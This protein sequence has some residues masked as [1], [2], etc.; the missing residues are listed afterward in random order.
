MTADA[1]RFRFGEPESRAADALIRLALAEDFGETGDLTS[2]ATIPSSARARARFVAR[3]PG[4][5]AGLPVVRRLVE[6]FELLDRWRP[7]TS[8]GD[9]LE[10]ATVIA[11]VSGPA[12]SILAVER[13]GRS[14]SSSRLCG[15]ATLTAR[16]VAAVQG[17]RARIFDTRKTTP[18][19]RPLEKYAVRCGGG[20]NHRIGLHD[21][22]LI[23]DNHL[24]ILRSEGVPDP[25]AAAVAAAR[26][27]APSGT[28][29]E[30]EVDT[31]EDLER[32]AG[33]PPRHRAPG[34]HGRRRVARAPWPGGDALAPGV[35]LEASGG[36]D[37]NT[38]GPLARAG[39]ERISV[40]A[41]HPLGP[42]P[43]HRP[44]FR[45][46]DGL[47]GP[48]DPRPGRVV[49]RF[50]DGPGRCPRG[51]PIVSSYPR[52]SP[53][54]NVVLLSRLREAGG[55]FVPPDRLGDDPEQVRADLD[56]LAGFG[57]QIERHPYRG[58]AYRGPAG[59]LCPDQVE[60]DLG[61]IR[62]GRRIAVWNRVASTSDLAA[63]AATTLAN[64]GLV[65]LAEDQTAG[66]GQRGRSWTVPPQSSV[67]LSTLLF[68]PHDRIPEGQ[69]A[70]AGC[71][72]LTALGAAATA[73]LA[74][75]WTG[76]DARIKWPNDVRVDGRKLAGILVERVRGPAPGRG[77]G[78]SGR[79]PGVVIGIGLNG[80]LAPED[81]A[82][83]CAGPPAR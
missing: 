35:E 41:A 51:S 56:A 33:L 32:A 67:L 17:T 57:F 19:W 49:A 22:V 39:V 16:F 59:R 20:Y 5:L 61:T 8:D 23:K 64:D 55:Q 21:A 69:G 31:L 1:A 66:R 47:S 71:A 43:R 52:G 74:C 80:N 75:D 11:E 62:I 13:T 4:V 24:A 48:A 65:V 68:P 14:T 40:G 46:V 76:A 78:E 10:P 72:W 12:R 6:Q 29:V 79:R 70:A 27:H 36:V 81:C 73:E 3:A 28:V 50:G 53:M 82:P 2:T 42:R 54:L 63:R 45:R 30:V 25:I 15:V 58:F 83:S 18:G 60:H 37:L 34:Q 38:V 26:A 44:G 9:P 7:H 77:S